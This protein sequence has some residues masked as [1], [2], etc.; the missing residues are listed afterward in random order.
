VVTDDFDLVVL[1]E[2]NPEDCKLPQ[3]ARAKLLVI[4]TKNSRNLFKFKTKPPKG[5]N[6]YFASAKIL[7]RRMSIP[8]DENRHGGSMAPPKGFNVYF[9][10][11]KILFRRMSIPSDENRHGGSMAP[12]KG[13]NVYFAS[14]KISFPED[15]HSVGRKPS[16]RKHG[17]SLKASY[18]YL[19]NIK[20]TL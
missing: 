12:P 3:A 13:F 20:F 16:R 17:T 2:P 9:A 8:S 11:A 10:S 14:A 15:V 6:V 1:V 4:K 5:F 18:V 7:F 19:K